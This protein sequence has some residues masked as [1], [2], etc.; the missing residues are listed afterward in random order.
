M[1]FN[2][3]QRGGLNLNAQVSRWGDSLHITKRADY[4]SN[5]K[6]ASSKSSG[7]FFYEENALSK[8]DAMYQYETVEVGPS[9]T[10]REIDDHNTDNAS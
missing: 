2:I 5:E 4:Y 8:S 7:Y 1:F 3:L 6:S 9:N 10:K